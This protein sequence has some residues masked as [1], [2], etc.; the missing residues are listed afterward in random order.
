MKALKK[1]IVHIREGKMIRYIVFQK[2][3]ELGG[4]TKAADVMG[5]S[6]SS[7]S[8]MI[9][10]LEKELGV[11]LLSRSHHEISLTPEGEAL[12]PYIEKAIYQYRAIKEKV[13]EIKGLDT[14]IIRIGTISSVSYQWLPDLVKGFQKMYP[15][16]EFVFYQGDYSSIGNWIQTGTVD[17]GFIT[18]PAVTGLQTQNIAEGEM[19]VIL[20]ENH[21]LAEKKYIELKDLCQEPFI[22]LEEGNYNEA[23]LAFEKEH[24]KP[25]IKFAVHDDFTIMKMVEKEMGVSILSELMVREAPYRLKVRSLTPPLYRSL[26]IGYRNKA[27]LPIA[28]RRFIEYMNETLEINGEKSENDKK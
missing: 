26:A 22:L 13:E 28:A 20:P 8:Q 4:F 5:Y 6:Q 16:V 1:T 2:V 18:P 24:L 17:F 14:G 7:V 25:D 10:S 15:N 9:A 19:Q 21:P 3:I 12:Y 11:Q 23:I 27:M